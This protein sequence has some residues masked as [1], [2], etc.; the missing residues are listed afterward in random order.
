MDSEFSDKEFEIN[1]K[2]RDLQLKE[3]ELHMK[4]KD[5]KQREFDI[6]N[7]DSP[8]DISSSR[9]KELNDR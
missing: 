3:D 9:M 7:A 4:S 6:M 1:Q 2:K 5:L 8:A